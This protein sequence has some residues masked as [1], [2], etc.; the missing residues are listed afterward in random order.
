MPASAIEI[1]ID[2]DD[3]TGR[4]VVRRVQEAGEVGVAHRPFQGE[5]SGQIVAGV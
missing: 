2:F 4:R 1:G 5:Y 3:P